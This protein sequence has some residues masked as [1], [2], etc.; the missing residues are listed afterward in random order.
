MTIAIVG[1]LHASDNKLRSRVDDYPTVC[2]D[3]L[4]CLLELHDHVIVLGDFFNTSTVS[5][6]Y[7]NILIK[8]L[9][10]YNGR[11]HS[12]LGNHDANYRTLNLD[13]TAIGLLV[14]ANVLKLHLD[15][16]ELEG[17]KFDVASVVPALKLPKKSADILLGHFYLDNHFAPKESF[18]LED[19]SEYKKV[20][21]GHDHCPYKTIITDTTD[22]YR[23]GSLTR[24]TSDKYN[25]ERNEIRY[26]VIEDNYNMRLETLVVEGAEKVFVPEAFNKEDN[27][28]C[29]DLTNL[30]NLI[31]SFKRTGLSEGLSTSKILTELE[32]PEDCFE[33]LKSLHSRLGLTF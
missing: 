14:N 33:Y 23:L 7:C 12:I 19:L 26:A 6:E 5:T 30:D 28:A 3:K 1:D 32:T 13:K 11:L 31:S 22:I 27:K 25:L 29:N 15:T 17:V 20:F 16:F 8:R 9:K 18:K 2:V 10:S 4:I 21:L 24:I